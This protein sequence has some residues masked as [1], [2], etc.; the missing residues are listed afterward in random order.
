[1]CFDTSEVVELGR[2][3]SL[4]LVFRD[5]SVSPTYTASHSSH[6]ILYTSP[7]YVL[8]T[9]GILR[10]HQQLSPCLKYV[11]IPY[12]PNT[13]LMCSENPFTYTI[14]TGISFAPSFTDISIISPD[15]ST[16]FSDSLLFSSLK[17]LKIHSG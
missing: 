17:S 8:F 5:L 4:N 1:M 13:H 2:R 12:F 16:S 11:E 7:N 6:M 15:V 10:F 9:H 3:C 14:T